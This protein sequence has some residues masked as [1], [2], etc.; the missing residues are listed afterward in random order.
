MNLNNKTYEKNTDEMCSH[1]NVGSGN[2]ISIIELAEMIKEVVNFKGNLELDPSKPDGSER[3]LMNS[4][5][6]NN[7][8]W[9]PDTDLKEG[10]KTT[11]KDF[12]S[13]KKFI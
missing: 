13:T 12:I 3:K 5:K 1:V 10:L 6:L 11:Y 7:L 8:G 2:D 4:L 9:L